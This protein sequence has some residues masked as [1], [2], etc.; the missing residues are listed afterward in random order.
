MILVKK[1]ICSGS[2]CSNGYICSG[3]TY[4]T[5]EGVCCP[6]ECIKQTE[7][8]SQESLSPNILLFQ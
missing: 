8:D 3:Q 1:T 7:Y 4:N 6:T 2:M 5:D